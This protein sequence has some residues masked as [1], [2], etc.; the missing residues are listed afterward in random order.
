MENSITPKIAL[1]LGARA[2]EYLL[3]GQPAA[4]TFDPADLDQALA[5]LRQMAATIQPAPGGRK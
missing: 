3:T 4:C 1:Y 2:C 5:L